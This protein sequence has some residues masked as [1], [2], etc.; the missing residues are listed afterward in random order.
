MI[1]SYCN[2]FCIYIIL[3]ERQIN[4]NYALLITLF[5]DN[6]SKLFLFYFSTFIIILSY[7]ISIEKILD[8]YPS[9]LVIPL[10]LNFPSFEL[11]Y[12]QHSLHK[13]QK[14]Y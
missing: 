1:V 13:L 11:N 10:E 8:T 12:I 4:Q 7:V 14:L 3:L 5:F 6:L 9:S 2:L